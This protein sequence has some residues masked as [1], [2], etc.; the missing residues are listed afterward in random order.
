MI[1]RSPADAPPRPDLT[2]LRHRSARIVTAV[3]P[4]APEIAAPTE[5]AATTSLDLSEPAAPAPAEP[6][7]PSGASA[8]AVAAPAWPPRRAPSGHRTVLSPHQPTVTLTRLQSG[9]G[10]LSIE[11]ICPPTVGDARL[12]VAYQLDDGR[13]GVVQYASGLVAAPADSRRP[14]IAAFHG[15]YDGVTLDLRQSRRLVR[16]AAYVFSESGRSL[17]WAGTLVATTFGG[18]RVE[19]P[20]E[21]GV[22]QG[23][24]VALS[25]YN[26]DGEYVLRA[27]RELVLG[28]ARE[29][30]RSF[31]FDE[32]TWVDGRTPLR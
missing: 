11:A 7:P 28:D 14:V 3:G 32:I 5:L 17:T 4:P 13:S 10:T 29:A 19:I 2:W 8:R 24:V 6:E 31:G 27:E 18:A 9:I 15:R 30:V 1:A 22:H 21:Y 26:I 20:L 23:P 25:L 12:G 16:L